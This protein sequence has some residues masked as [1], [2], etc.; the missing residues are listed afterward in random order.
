V[1]A[2]L[3]VV[4]CINQFFAGI[5]GEEAAGMPPQ[6]LPGPRGPG[7]LLQSLA[8][9]LVVTAT[10]AFGD[11]D[12]AA[13]TEAAV[14]QV[15]TLLRGIDPPDLVI[16]GPAFA[17]GRYG[18]ACAAICRAVREQL[19]I[20]A[21]TALHPDNPAVDAYRRD[22]PI[23]RA[24]RDVI[25]MR[26]ALRQLLAV[27]RKLVRGEVLDPVRD[28]LLTRG[29]R[30]NAFAETTGAE[31][32]VT[33]LSHKVR[34][35]PFETEYPMPVFDRVAPAPPVA[36]L[37]SATIALVTSGG[38]VPR[39]N[40]DHI[41]SA[42]ASRYGEYS[43]AG[44]A[45][46][47][48]DTHETVHGGYDPTYAN[49]DPNRVLPV[50]ALR[51]LEREGRI[52]RLYPRYFA[53]VGNGTSPRRSSG[54]DFPPLTFVRS[55]RSRGPSEPTASCPAWRFPTRWEIP[56]SHGRRSSNSAAAW[57]SERWPPWHSQSK[58][59]VSLPRSVHRAV[60]AWW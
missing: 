34:G 6:L 27:G 9:D 28:G 8:P 46:L 15:L 48:P 41:E 21:L 10:V 52:G 24:E 44:I 1:V 3:R 51:A 12:V 5:G 17:A 58:R 37:A 18:I 39:G 53:T 60:H 30:K 4:H 57:W 20:P 56:S 36:E 22:V 55:C 16:A 29:V 2:R 31:R 40:P 45:A 19:G 11:N 35:A 23:V 14:A 59:S 47:S 33:M 32:A 50:D 42:N 7:V 26:D 25:G 38:I 43:L 54:P 49:A 13:R